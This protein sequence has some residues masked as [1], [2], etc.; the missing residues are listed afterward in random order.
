MNLKEFAIHYDRDPNNNF[1]V[2]CFDTNSVAELQDSHDPRD[3]DPIDLRAWHIN[4]D[5]W[6]DAV[7]A[8]L[9]EKTKL[10]SR[11]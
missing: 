6:A 9:E 10:V 4:A 11:R 7:Q 2:A 8:A 5:E 1:A 3:A